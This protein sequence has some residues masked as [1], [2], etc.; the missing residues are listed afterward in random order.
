MT[1][2]EGKA[3][4]QPQLRQLKAKENLLNCLVYTLANAN[5]QVTNVTENDFIDVMDLAEKY[6]ARW[7]IF[8]GMIP[9]SKDPKDLKAAPSPTQYEWAW[10]KLYDLR[11]KYKGKPDVN[12][13][14]PTFARVAKQRGIAD[15]D[16]WFNRFFLGRCFFGKF[17]V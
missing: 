2:S 6:G 14:Y 4:M 8:H 12:I 17:R 1:S 3:P 9:Y 10:N 15:W 13:Y 16:N 11:I 7:V 5:E